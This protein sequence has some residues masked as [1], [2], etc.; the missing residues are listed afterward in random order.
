MSLRFTILLLSTVI[1][2]P[3]CS[4]WDQLFAP[5]E[6]KVQPE[7]LRPIKP[8]VSLKKVWSTRVGV[9]QGSKYLKL[10]PAIDGNKI[11]VSDAKGNVSA[12]NRLS[13]GQLWRIKLNQPVSGAVGAGDNKII[14]GTSDGEVFALNQTDGSTLWQ[15]RVS[16]E[17]LSPP[18]INSDI[19]IVQTLDGKLYGFNPDSGKR[20]WVYDG[21]VPKLTLRGTSTPLLTDKLAVAG[22]A[23]GKI[24]GFNNTRGLLRWEQNS[25]VPRGRS[26]LERIIDVDG[27]IVL[28]DD[29]NTLYA[30]SYRGSIIAVQLETGRMRWQRDIASHVAVGMGFNDYIYVSDT[31]GRVWALDDRNSASLWRQIDLRGRRLT[32]PVPFQSYV[33]VGDYEGYLHLLSVDDGRFVARTR[34]DSNGLRSAPIAANDLLYIYGNG[35]RLTAYKVAGL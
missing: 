22:F 9:G 12:F 7:G 35:G 26:E 18:Q 3:G 6:E 34:V 33:A 5:K 19:A 1:L 27:P 2:L 29:D 30:S 13:G 10:S 24:L 15:S 21:K 32:S 16:S 31:K 25:A 17:V 20:L 23:N 8:E 28:D 11:F 14:L 4:I